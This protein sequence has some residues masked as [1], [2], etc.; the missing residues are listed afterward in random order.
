VFPTR[1]Q[2]NEAMRRRPPFALVLVALVAAFGGLFALIATSGS[3]GGAPVTATGG[4]A[5]A[6]AT[7][8][9]EAAATARQTLEAPV[10]AS[11]PVSVTEHARRLTVTLSETVVERATAT[12]TVDVRRG[13]VVS[14][15]ACA[16]APTFDAAHGTAL[17]RAY[18]EALAAA[19]S[20]AHVAAVHAAKV[21]AAR[22]LPIL[23]ADARRKLEAHAEATAASVRQ[24]LLREA[25][26]R[27]ATGR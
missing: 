27:A 5:R 17:T 22:Q 6:C 25:R 11:V 7:A 8:R 14:R 2:S 12:R 9:A 19:R 3:G 16:H 1:W 13:A 26:A 4:P 20:K 21:F 23:Q 15:R 24:R 18:K 10:D